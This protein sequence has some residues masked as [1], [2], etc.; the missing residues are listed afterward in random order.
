MEI[1]EVTQIRNNHTNKEF[2]EMEGFIL[3][4][5]KEL[6]VYYDIGSQ[7]Q[8]DDNA[9][10]LLSKYDREIRSFLDQPY[11]GTFS[12]DEIAEMIL[13]QEYKK[14]NSSEEAAT[15]GLMK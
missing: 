15:L 7:S 9:E 13:T 5:L 4:S 2:L 8:A 10:Y 1:T 6:Y 14:R 12:P 3:N 11:G